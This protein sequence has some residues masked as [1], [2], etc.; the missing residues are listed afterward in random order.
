MD[1]KL[2]YETLL[3]EEEK[4]LLIKKC[5]IVKYANHDIIFKQDTLTSH[6]MFIKKGL[7]K[8]YKEIRND[9]VHIIRL[10]ETGNFIGLLSIFSEKNHQFS[11][12]SVGESEICFIDFSAF[13]QVVMQNNTFAYHMISLISQD[14]IFILDKLVGQ[15]YKQLPGRIADMLLYF[16]EVIYKSNRFTIPLTRKEMAEQAG[17]T[18][19][20]LIRTLTELKNDKITLALRLS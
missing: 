5:N 2:P 17:T 12:A 7:V 14:S 11:A 16:S 18:K 20:S 13:K 10:K 3:T 4:S 19:E 9:K 8:I 1:I 15:V 6:V